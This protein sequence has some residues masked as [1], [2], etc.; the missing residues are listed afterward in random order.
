[1]G[2][3]SSR[4]IQLFRPVTVTNAPRLAT[5]V[6][7]IGLL[8]WLLIAFVPRAGDYDANRALILRSGFIGLAGLVASFACSP[9]GRWFSWSGAVTMR[10]RLG[11]YGFLF[12]CVHVLGYAWL[13][14]DFSLNL[15]LRDLLERRAMGIGM[16]ALVLLIPLAITST[17]GWQR[18]LGRRWRM[19]HRLVF[20]AVPLSVAHF[21]LLDRDVLTA[22]YVFAAIALV[23]VLARWRR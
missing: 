14:N 6:I 15:M 13:D 12:V 5:H 7:A 4:P 17:R 16:L 23:L 10:R 21:L 18:R 1:M 11:L 22:A 19:L 9:I 3:L 8:A 2:R 20:L